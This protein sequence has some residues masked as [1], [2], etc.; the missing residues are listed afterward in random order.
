MKKKIEIYESAMC[1]PTGLCGPSV[2][3]DVLRIS[4]V[5]NS[6]EKKEV[7]IKRYNLTNNTKEFVSNKIINELLSKE[8]EKVLPVTLVD[9]KVEKKGEYPSNDDFTKWTG[10]TIEKDKPKKADSGCCSDSNVCSVD[11]S[12]KNKKPN[13]G[14]GDKGCC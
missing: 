2:N 12:P 4:T 13:L 8:G 10:I 11:C 14:C 1:C 9:G 7:A 5:V 3:S 6:L